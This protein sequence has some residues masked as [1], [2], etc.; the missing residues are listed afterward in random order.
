MKKLVYVGITGRMGSGKDTVADSIKKHYDDALI[1][2]AR[3]AAPIKEVAAL[4]FD[5]SPEVLQNTELKN[6]TLIPFQTV[7]A[8]ISVRGLLQGIGTAM[9]G[10]HTNFWV[11]L[12]HRMYGPKEFIKNYGY[13]TY[14][15]DVVVLIPDLRYKNEEEYIRRKNGIII[16]VERPQ[17]LGDN[18]IHA[19]VS[20]TSHASICEDYL[21][22]NNGTVE[23]LYQQTTE[24][25]RMIKECKGV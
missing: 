5:I 2:I 11:E 13:P 23:D 18:S 9:R 3:F 24:V 19:H 22:S 8:S 20:E 10:I 17:E 4:Y 15:R 21:V 16:K 12:F 7:D 6:T 1:H 25:I 14:D